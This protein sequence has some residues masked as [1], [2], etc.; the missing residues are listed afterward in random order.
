MTLDPHALYAGHVFGVL[1]SMGYDIEPVGDH[2]G[3]LTG[4]FWLTVPN[5][6]LSTDAG[7]KVFL[8]VPEPPVDW[9]P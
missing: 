1:T 9:K 8:A 5:R 2:E 4:R 7:P 6:A 3:N